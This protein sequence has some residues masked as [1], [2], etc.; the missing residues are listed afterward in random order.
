MKSILTKM[1]GGL[2]FATS[3]LYL[4]GPELGF[5]ATVGIALLI[6]GVQIA[7]Y[8]SKFESK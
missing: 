7:E 5:K 3:M 1:L 2:V 6:L 8:G 4:I